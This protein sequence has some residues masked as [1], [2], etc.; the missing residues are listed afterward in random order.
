MV[1]A[2][3]KLL[4]KIKFAPKIK[5][6]H[7]NETSRSKLKSRTPFSQKISL[8]TLMPMVKTLRNEVSILSYY[9]YSRRIF[10]F[11]FESHLEFLKDF[12]WPIVL[13][14]SSHSCSIGLR[15]PADLSIKWI[16]TS[17]RRSTVVTENVWLS[18][19]KDYHA[20]RLTRRGCLE[21]WADLI[22]GFFYC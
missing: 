22:L 15:E 3:P 16:W 6:K 18:C 7:L 14:R 17:Y 9:K 8:D 20:V 12:S 13:I 10:S 21:D 11:L 19:S 5:K 1:L 2:R 4:F